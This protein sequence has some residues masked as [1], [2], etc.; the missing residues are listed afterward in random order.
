MHGNIQNI[1]NDFDSDALEAIPE[2]SLHRNVDIPIVKADKEGYVRA[3]LIAPGTVFGVPTGRLADL[4]VQNKRSI[5]LSLLFKASIDRKRAGMLGLGKNVWPA[6]SVRDTADLFMLVFNIA[7]TSPDALGH[8]RDGFYIAETCQYAVY[9]VMKEAGRVL[10]E[11]GIAEEAE[12]LPFSEEE[13]AKYFGFIAP[14]L[15]TNCAAKGVRSRALGWK[16]A[17]GKDEFMKTIE[18]GLMLCLDDTPLRMAPNSKDYS[19]TLA[20]LQQKSTN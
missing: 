17:D 13:L 4:G 12:P 7:R 3:Y 18:D 19:D 16:P 2:T 9:E 1:S 15:G 14:I 10:V 8:G 20:L 5:Q 6:V 11:L